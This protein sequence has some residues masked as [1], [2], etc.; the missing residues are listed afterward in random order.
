MR[1]PV[2]CY[3]CRMN[4][5]VRKSSPEDVPRLFEVWRTAVR[6]TH[7]FVAEDDHREIAV[8]V[9]DHYLPS[10][11][12]DLVVDDNDIPLAFMGMTDN[13]IDSLFVHG[14]ARGSGAGRILVELAFSRAPVVFTEVN[15][16]NEQGVGFWKHMGF[17]EIGRKEVDGQGRPYPLL[18]MRWSTDE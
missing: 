17:A 18:R 3:A 1:R 16:Q 5:R 13:E 9:R 12:L 4:F 2:V 6:D 10:A 7:E 15:E 11:D 14:D 8:M